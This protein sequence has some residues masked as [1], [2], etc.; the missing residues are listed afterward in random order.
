MDNRQYSDL[1]DRIYE[2]DTLALERLVDMFYERLTTFAKSII[3]SEE[4]ADEVV[5]DVFLRVWQNRKN[6]KKIDKIE[7]YLYV[8]V[9]NIAIN[10]LKKER[11]TEFDV[12][13][14]AHITVAS[15]DHTPEGS[16]ISKE[17]LNEINQAVDLLPSKCKLIFKLIR[18][19]GLKRSEVAE[20]L[21]LS[22][23]TID[24]QIAIAVK[25]I[26]ETL[27]IDLSVPSNRS[28]IQLFLLTL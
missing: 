11:K 27:R 13:D 24:N 6:I 8:S 22:V 15:Y 1:K 3:K 19:D 7:T 21:D 5:M 28:G 16:I 18:E 10:Y 9:K 26:A 23:K 12:L 17:M 20:I 25:K 2:N 14:E 4:L